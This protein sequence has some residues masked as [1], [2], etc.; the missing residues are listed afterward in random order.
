MCFAYM[1]FYKAIS[2]H[3][4]IG[5]NIK[6]DIKAFFKALLDEFGGSMNTIRNK[7]E[8]YYKSL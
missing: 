5:R 8:L 3:I 2:K 4:A 1:F 6:Q 7:A